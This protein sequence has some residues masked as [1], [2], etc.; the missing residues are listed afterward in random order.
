MLIFLTI[1]TNRLKM[2]NQPKKKWHEH[3]IAL[4]FFL[5]VI[6]PLGLILMWGRKAWT[7]QHRLVFTALSVSVFFLLPQVILKLAEQKTKSKEEEIARK[8]IDPRPGSQIGFIEMISNFR[9]ERDENIG[10]EYITNEIEERASGFLEK[11]IMI[12]NWYGRVD[13][14]TGEGDDCTI[15]VN[16]QSWPSEEYI[17]GE[18]QKTIQFGDEGPGGIIFY[19]KTIDRTPC[20]TLQV[21]DRVLISGNSDGEHSWSNE[22]ALDK[23]EIGLNCTEITK[24]K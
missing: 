19:C 5:L 8:F 20:T 11:N 13:R 18:Y 3:S 16:V 9:Q 7:L 21:G 4:V 22:G 14:I 17:N 24:T 15:V 23:P 12:N 1:T 2:N 10:N 6:P